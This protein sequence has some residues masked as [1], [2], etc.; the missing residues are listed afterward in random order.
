MEICVLPR[1][2]ATVSSSLADNLVLAPFEELDIS[3]SEIRN[4]IQQ[5]LSVEHLVCKSVAKIIE[6]EGLYQN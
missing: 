6:E 4:K 2:G 1:K 3:S 5:N